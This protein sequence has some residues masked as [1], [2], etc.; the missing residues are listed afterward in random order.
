VKRNST[1]SGVSTAW[2]PSR[3]VSGLSVTA[4]V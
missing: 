4:P 3:R 2:V 1:Y